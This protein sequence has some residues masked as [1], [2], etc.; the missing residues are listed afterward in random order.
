MEPPK[1]VV[2]CY[3][4]KYDPFYYCNN[5]GDENHFSF[6][7]ENGYSQAYNE[8]GVKIDGKYKIGLFH[9]CTSCFPREEKYYHPIQDI[10][11]V[12]IINPEEAKK[13]QPLLDLEGYPEMICLRVG[14]AFIEK[15]L[16]TREMD[17]DYS[18]IGWE[19]HLNKYIFKEG[20][21]PFLPVESY[22]L[23]RP[24]IPYPEDFDDDHGGYSVYTQCRSPKTGKVFYMELSGD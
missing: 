7:E 19:G 21:E 18:D 8:K 10:Y 3:S 17:E 23:F 14:L 11:D 24:C 2:V 15:V 20:F 16:D 13:L 22:D 5:C 4:E 9:P 12:E 1:Y 6:S